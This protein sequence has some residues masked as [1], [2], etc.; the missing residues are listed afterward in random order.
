MLEVG[1]K[2]ASIIWSRMV[3]MEPTASI[4]ALRNAGLDEGGAGLALGASYADE[5]PA[6]MMAAPVGIDDQADVVMIGGCRRRRRRCG[7][8]AR[9]VL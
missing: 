7:S 6:T 1:Q 3:K 8:V 4:P 2:I 5:D 9:W